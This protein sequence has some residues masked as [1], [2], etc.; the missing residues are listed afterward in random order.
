MKMNRRTT[1]I[2][3]TAHRP[4]QR[5]AGLIEVLVAVLILAL[6][7]LGMAGLQANALKKNQSSFARS[8]AVM[9]S[10]YMLDAMRA[11]RSAAVSGSYDT[12]SSGLCSST[13]LTGTALADNTRKDW[14]DSLRSNLGDVDSTCGIIDCDNAGVCSITVKW[15][16]ELAGGLGAQ[17]F[18]TRSR[19]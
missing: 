13:A 10:Y 9:L 1:D 7:L 11:D 19:L 6:G 3:W 16:D 12:A 5:G 8:Q 2:R 18:E 4:A 17:T 14:V 15:N